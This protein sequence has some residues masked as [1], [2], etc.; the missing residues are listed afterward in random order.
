MKK[1]KFVLIKLLAITILIIITSCNTNKS[2]PQNNTP[3]ID[4][5]AQKQ[6]TKISPVTLPKKTKQSNM[7]ASFETNILDKDKDRI[8]NLQLAAKSINGYLLN[9]NEIFSFN[10][11]VGKRS[12]ENGYEKA[13]IIENGKRVEDFGGGVCQISSTIFGAVSKL[14]FLI[15][16]KH[17]HEKDVHY[18]KKGQD[19]AVDFLNMDFKFK[20]TKDYPIK[21]A[22]TVGNNKVSVF[23][24]K[25]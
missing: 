18:V 20:N 14:G 15:I 3:K 23:I 5:Y 24:F 12:P 21:I 22:V 25:E 1:N 9:P 8:K 13:K 11:V 19:A 4:I 2:K 6:L 17:E 16:E 7:L 10:T